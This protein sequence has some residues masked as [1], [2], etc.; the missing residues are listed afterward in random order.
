MHLTLAV[1]RTDELQRQARQSQLRREARATR[2]ATE[3]RGRKAFRI[4]KPVH[5]PGLIAPRIAD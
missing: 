3:P 2:K 4:F 1:A 5:R